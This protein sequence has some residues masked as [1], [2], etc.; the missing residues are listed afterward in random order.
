MDKN[1]QALIAI[2]VAIQALDIV[3]PDS[4]SG[5]LVDMAHE[6]LLE[7][8]RNLIGKPYPELPNIHN[9]PLAE[10]LWFERNEAE[11]IADGRL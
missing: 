7:A 6:W 9:H 11:Q 8:R 5:D 2:N 10:Q 1:R 3:P 4:T